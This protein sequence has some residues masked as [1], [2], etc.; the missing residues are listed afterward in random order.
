METESHIEQRIREVE[1]QYQSKGYA[2]TVKPRHDQLPDFLSPY[3]PAVLACGDEESVIVEV[4]SGA[5]LK[6]AD[7]LKELAQTIQAHSG[8]RFELVVVNPEEFLFVFEDAR[9][10]GE[11]E[12]IQ[13]LRVRDALM[14]GFTTQK[15]APSCVRELIETTRQ[16]LQNISEMLSSD[17]ERV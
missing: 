2:V 6:K 12:I 3:Q 17:T 4:K 16:Q 5:A 15:F 13:A 14:H 1:R 11:Q 9:P 7:S 10:L 8:W